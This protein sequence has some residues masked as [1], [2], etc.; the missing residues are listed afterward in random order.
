ML[1]Q[2]LLPHFIDIVLD[3]FPIF[4]QLQYRYLSPT[5]PQHIPRYNYDIISQ[6][7]SIHRLLFAS[8]RMDVDWLVLVYQGPIEADF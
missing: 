8:F 2:I 1:R 5:L 4:K 3:V 7:S 6:S